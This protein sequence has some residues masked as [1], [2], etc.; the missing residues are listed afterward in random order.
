M[1]KIEAFETF[2]EESRSAVERTVFFRISRREDAEDVL[3][4]VYLTA[5]RKFDM[6]MDHLSFKAWIISIAR[7]KCVDYY[8]KRAAETEHMEEI[9]SEKSM[10]YGR[11]GLRE[12]VLVRDTL[13]LLTKKDQKILKLHYFEELPQAEIARKLKIPLGTVKSRLHTARENFREIYPGSPDT[14]LQKDMQKQFYNNNLEDICL[15]V[16]ENNMENKKVNKLIEGT[17]LPK[18]LPEYS[19]TL[20]AEPPFET[21][22]EELQGW[23]IV[24]RIGES[25]EWGLYAMPSR[26][27]TEY[28]KLEV[29]GAAQVHGIEGV[30]I[31][32]VQYDAQDYYRT[33]SVNRMERRFA[34][35][36][37]D[38]HSRYLAESHIE[39][40]VRKCYTFLDGDSF[41]KNWG[42]G[43]DNCGNE[44]HIAAKG[45]LQR[46]G[47]I[48][49]FCKG[50]HGSQHLDVVGRYTV[51]IAGKVYDTICVMDV[52][53]Y[54][55]AI[56]TESYI[57]KNGRTVLW[58]RFN[59]DNWAVGQFR[60][61]SWSE[62]L[63]GNERLIVDGKVYVHWYDCVSD[64]IL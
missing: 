33:G 17:I 20:S 37:T 6:L 50:V 45:I 31:V 23:M 46:T 8:R 42:F 29:T 36:L 5:Y 49:E 62:E 43:E 2:L 1:G 34:A 64:Y 30:E 56:V 26:G 27:R 25:I 32:A 52:E 63:P 35:Q 14:G 18:S 54:D 53:S 58:R 48:V 57:D 51:E 59:S 22:W 13:A 61:K 9:L 16:K 11:C 21:V 60:I 15:T 38:T 7:N 4:E 44:T 3:Q 12:Q 10:V 28:A 39:D 47:N 19:I 41:M 55:D 24:P 40:G